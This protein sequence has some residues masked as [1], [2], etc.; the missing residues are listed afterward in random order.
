[1]DVYDTIQIGA[2]QTDIAV[3]QTMSYTHFSPGCLKSFE[4]NVNLQFEQY[5]QNIK[6]V[7]NTLT[8]KSL[9]QL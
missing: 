1:M 6:Y 7:P 2:W 5:S 9:S 3:D 4:L 8:P